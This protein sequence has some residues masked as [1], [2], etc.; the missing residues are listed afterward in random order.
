MLC[1]RRWNGTIHKL[2]EN[3]GKQFYLYPIHSPS[4]SDILW[5]DD[6]TANQCAFAPPTFIKS[7]WTP[8]QKEI[9]LFYFPEQIPLHQQ[10][11]TCCT[12]SSFLLLAQSNLLLPS[13]RFRNSSLTLHKTHLRVTSFPLLPGLSH[14]LLLRQAN[15]A[16]LPPNSSIFFVFFISCTVYS[17]IFVVSAQTLC[18][19]ANPP[20]NTFHNCAAVNILATT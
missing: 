20:A 11:S 18:L 13:S 4:E 9:T 2:P 6:P 7:R 19:P 14:Q 15:T 5:A 3:S 12:P 1:R 17:C 10:V 8:N 16:C